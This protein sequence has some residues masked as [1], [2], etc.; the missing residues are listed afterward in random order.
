M[1]GTKKGWRLELPPLLTVP[2]L[3]LCAFFLIFPLVAVIGTS[4]QDGFSGWVRVMQNSTYFTA[5][6]QSLLLAVWTTAE[7]SV[8]GAA[9]ALVWAHRLKRH[10]WFLAILNF[11]AH[12]GGI[13]LAFAIM[14]TLGTNGML[15]ILLKQVGI[16]L[17]PGFQL[18]SIQGLHWAYLSFLIP[19]MSMIFLPAAGAL[20]QDWREAASTLGAGRL[21]Y[22]FRVAGPVLL[23]AY[24]SS[25]ALVFL[26]ALGTYATAQA[27]S[28]NNVNLLTIQIG[29]LIQQSLFRHADANALSF[30]LL[31]MMVFVV[32]IYRS[33]NRKAARWLE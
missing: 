6:K 5:L 31:I 2:Y 10:G 4:F 23:P 17:Y 16:D 14:A 1:S 28:G 9:L 22:A 15:T 25:A 29:Y 19:F 27:I 32:L 3:V 33:A 11:A 7:A 24:L 21:Q 26:Q 30:I 12:N 8:A 18:S 13:S 20:R